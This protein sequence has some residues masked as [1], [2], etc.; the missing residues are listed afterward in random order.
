MFSMKRIKLTIAVLYLV[1]MILNLVIHPAI[2]ASDLL[3]PA[4]Q[5]PYEQPAPSTDTVL[6]TV[7]QIGEDA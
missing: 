7:P 2:Y 6:L 3:G 5:L 1:Q 4:D